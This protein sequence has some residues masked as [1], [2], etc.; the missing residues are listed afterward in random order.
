M[1]TSTPVTPALERRHRRYA[2]D[3]TNKEWRII[4]PFLVR[5]SGPGHPQVLDLR[6][7]VNSI[8]YLNRTGCQW[9]M[10]PRDFPNWSSIYY[11]FRKWSRDGTWRR[12]NE[13]LFVLVR[14]SVQKE[15]SPSAAII[16]SQS[17]KTTEAG[18]PRGYDAGKQVKGRKRHILVDTLGL[19]MMVVIHPANIQDY[20]GA[21]LVLAK[22]KGQFPRLKRI[23]A[24]GIYGGPL[25]TW[26]LATLGVILSIVTRDPG[27]KGFKVLPK[28]WIVERTLG[29]FGRYRRLSK[30]YEHDLH[31]SEAMVYL[32]SIRVMLRR[33]DKQR[34]VELAA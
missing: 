25:V 4:R 22:I 16:D 18:G 7:I 28:R 33:L 31:T 13:A 15:A 11:H 23:W 6:L 30:D 5:S 34:Q 24:D 1:T 32:A 8:F 21:K 20:H 17:V 19:L 26:V 14:R 3:L 2:S 10:I 9:R 29:W 27:Q 12:I